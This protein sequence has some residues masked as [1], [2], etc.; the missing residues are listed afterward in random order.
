MQKMV[1]LTSFETFLLVHLVAIW[2]STRKIVACKG[3]GHCQNCQL[4]IR[5][6]S[7]T[8]LSM[9]VSRALL[10]MC[11]LRFDFKSSSKYVATI[12]IFRLLLV[13]VFEYLFQEITTL[14]GDEGRQFVHRTLSG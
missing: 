13:F 14:S 12:E 7:D 1:G 8:S 5:G 9:K 6:I 10:S 2:E 4:P 11:Y 3:T